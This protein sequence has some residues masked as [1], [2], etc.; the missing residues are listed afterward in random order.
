L[1]SVIHICVIV[2]LLPNRGYNFFTL[3]ADDTYCRLPF[4]PFLFADDTL[5]V[6]SLLTQSY[7]LS[8]LCQPRK[9]YGFAS[10]FENHKSLLENGRFSRDF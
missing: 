7:P 3:S 10:F 5:F 2:F 9:V 1:Y 6:F 4:S 8:G